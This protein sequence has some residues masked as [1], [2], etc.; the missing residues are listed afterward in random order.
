MFSSFDP[1][2]RYKVTGEY[3]PESRVMYFDIATAEEA[4]HPNCLKED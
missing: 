4:E 2:K 3:D 1:K